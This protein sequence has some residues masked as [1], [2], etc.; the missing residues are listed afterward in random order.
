MREDD[1]GLFRNGWGQYGTQPVSLVIDIVCI[2]VCSHPTVTNRL[3]YQ[4]HPSAPV[5]ECECHMSILVCLNLYRERSRFVITIEINHNIGEWD[6][7]HAVFHAPEA[8][9]AIVVGEI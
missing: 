2:K 5:G 3:P 4:K 7:S 6:I 8:V 9:N 1:T